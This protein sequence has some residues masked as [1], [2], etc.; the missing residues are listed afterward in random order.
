MCDKGSQTCLFWNK[1]GE[2]KKIT[3]YTFFYKKP[4]FYKK[5]PI[6][7]KFLI[8]SLKYHV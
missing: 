3:K 8:Y 4:V 5:G 1:F 6:F 7:K 2:R